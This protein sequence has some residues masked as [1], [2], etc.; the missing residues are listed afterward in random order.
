[1]FSHCFS[2]DLIYLLVKKKMIKHCLIQLDNAA[3]DARPLSKAQHSAT[4]GHISLKLL[5][6][7]TQ[8]QTHIFAVTRHVCHSDDVVAGVLE[9]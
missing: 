4:E 1:M 7:Y 3:S 2:N 9:T 8:Y 6:S 5:T